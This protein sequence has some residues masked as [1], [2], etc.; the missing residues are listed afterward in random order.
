MKRVVSVEQWAEVR[1]MHFV[2]GLGIRE[3]GRRTGLHRETVRRALRSPMPPS[4]ERPARGSKLDSFRDEVLAL[5]R[6]EPGIES[7]RIR[8]F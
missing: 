6:C 5:L 8:G 4:Y 2:D 7:Q 1:R 3:I